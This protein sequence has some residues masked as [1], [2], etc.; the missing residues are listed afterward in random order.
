MLSR[1]AELPEPVRGIIPPLITPLLDRDRLDADG[2]ARLVEHV[3]AGGVHGLFVLGTTGEG[4]SLGHRLRCEM[5]DRV[6]ELV[7]GRVPV[8]VGISDTSFAESL[9]LADYAADAGA[10]AVVLAPP[11]YYPV[12]QEDLTRYIE[13]LVAELPLPLLLYDIPSHTGIDFEL[14]SIRGLIDLPGVVGLKD[15]SGDMVRLHRERELLDVYPGATLLV[16]PDELLG[17]AVLLGADGGV[18]GGANLA[19]LLFVDLYEAAARGDVDTV[20][21]LHKRV[22]QI[23]QRIYTVPDHPAPVIAG[24]KAALAHLGICTDVM[25]APLPPLGDRQRDVIDRAMGELGLSDSRIS[26]AAAV[27]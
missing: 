13:E 14:G 3:L 24:L 15:S 8:L 6:C 23:S 10:S 27:D 5:I 26:R 12:R 21:G 19:P 18:S 20:A 7:D 11:F 16:G 4:P 9:N 17:E 2:L 25:A 1:S 22:M